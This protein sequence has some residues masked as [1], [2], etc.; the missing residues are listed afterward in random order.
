MYKK[1]LIYHHHDN[2][3]YLAA[4][5]A[6][7]HLITDPKN[8]IRFTVGKYDSH[9]DFDLLKWADEIYIL[10]YSLPKAVMERFFDKIIWIDHHKPAMINI[11]LLESS[12]GKEIRG[13][14]EIGKSGCLLTWEYFNNNSNKIPRVTELVNDRDVWN[15][16]FGDDTA[17]FHEAS[18]MFSSSLTTW[19]ALLSNDSQTE[20]E[21][22]RGKTLLSFI[23]D[24]VDEY[25][26]EFAWEATFEGH[27]AVIMNGSSKISGELHKRLREN[28]PDAE[29]AVTFMMN[30]EQV[31]VGMYRQ[32]HSAVDLSKIA[33]K[34]GGGGHEGAA[35]FYI[36][37]EGWCKLLNDKG[38]Q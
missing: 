31:S 6:Y 1:V 18:R 19:L 17:A 32:D 16:H 10:D 30:K 8:Y 24:I 38:T 2:D 14:R 35:G 21:V 22:E 33:L 3:G 4:A 15:W 37:Y 34:Y 27:K 11:G 5:T 13:I 9:I 36:D 20:H 23:R 25:N 28:H 7:K 12:L 26:K 29:F